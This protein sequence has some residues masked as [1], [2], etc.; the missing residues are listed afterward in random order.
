MSKVLLID[1][2]QEQLTLRRMLLEHHGF[3]P[4]CA[5]DP[6]TALRVARET[7][8]EI[9]VVDLGLPTE[10][11][12]W[13]LISRLKETVP[14]LSIIVLSGTSRS[15]AHSHPQSHFVNAWLTKGGGTGGLI[16]ALHR[17]AA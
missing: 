14:E 10:E 17:F 9:A 8:P 15:S 2:D 13:R 1:D 3:D 4:R 16:D 12:G 7:L 6:E 11:H 5:S